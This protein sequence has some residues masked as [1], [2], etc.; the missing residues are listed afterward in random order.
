MG[1]SCLAFAAERIFDPAVPF[2]E[3]PQRRAPDL[4]S[5][6]IRE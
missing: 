3:A 1:N 4:A 6:G 5:Y 2:V